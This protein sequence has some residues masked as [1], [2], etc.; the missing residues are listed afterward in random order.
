MIVA[1]F[2]SFW[3]VYVENWSRCCYDIPKDK[4]L[5]LRLAVKIFN[6]NRLARIQYGQSEESFARSVQIWGSE[7]W[8]RR[9]NEYKLELRARK[10]FIAL[11]RR[12]CLALGRQTILL[13]GD[14]DQPPR[15]S[16]YLQCKQIKESSTVLVYDH[17][18]LQYMQWIFYDAATNKQANAFC[19][20]ELLRRCRS[21]FIKKERKKGDKIWRTYFKIAE[22]VLNYRSHF[23]KFV[24]FFQQRGL[25]VYKVC[26]FRNWFHLIPRYIL[27]LFS[28]NVICLEGTGFCLLQK[29]LHRIL[30]I[31]KLLLLYFI[32][33]RIFFQCFVFFLNMLSV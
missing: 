19:H 33:F 6:K 2:W 22:K 17:L 15:P 29:F 20:Y 24:A 11:L 21:I 3:T 16:T 32:L 26:Q 9:R 25:F 30:L 4:F 1:I 10:F 12:I 27:K 28:L 31:S 7:Q 18:H 8:K 5:I 13:R 23:E 14:Q